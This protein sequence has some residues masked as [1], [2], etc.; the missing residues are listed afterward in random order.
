[1]PFAGVALE[2]LSRGGALHRT[3]AQRYMPP[4]AGMRPGAA[5]AAEVNSIGNAAGS[6]KALRHRH[7]PAG[8]QLTGHILSDGSSSNSGSS[9]GGISGGGSVRNALAS[10]HVKLSVTSF[11][12]RLAVVAVI[13]QI[14]VALYFGVRHQ[15]CVIPPNSAPGR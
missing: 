15:R 7:Q 9:S 5:K 3:A 12:Y 6:S 10:L 1:M 11:W 13:L 8:L 2:R 4:V 14:P